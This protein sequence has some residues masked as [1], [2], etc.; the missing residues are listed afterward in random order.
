M[1]PE[2]VRNIYNEKI[3]YKKIGAVKKQ[4]LVDIESRNEETRNHER[5][6]HTRNIQEKSMRS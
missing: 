5:R 2:L 1:M 4:T 6:N 3:Q